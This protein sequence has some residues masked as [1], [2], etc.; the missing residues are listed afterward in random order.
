MENITIISGK[1]YEDFLREF[2]KYEA[3]HPDGNGMFEPNGGIYESS[4]HFNQLWLLEL[5]KHPNVIDVLRVCG[6]FV[7]IIVVVL[8]CEVLLTIQTIIKSRNIKF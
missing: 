8:L 6:L 3:K 2:N 5:A 1:E 7:I 4:Q